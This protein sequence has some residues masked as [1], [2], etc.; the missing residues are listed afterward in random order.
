M[1]SAHAQFLSTQPVR[2]GNTQHSALGTAGSAKSSLTRATSDPLVTRVSRGEYC[3]RQKKFIKQKKQFQGSGPTGRCHGPTTATH[4]H[5][6]NRRHHRRRSTPPPPP[7]HATTATQ[8]H[9]R[10]PTPPP[11]SPPATTTCPPSEPDPEAARHHHPPARRRSPS[12][13]PSS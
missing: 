11:L 6:Q 4:H 7:Q 10:R 12:L 5:H 3:S 13:T 9:R 1:L 8:H 2:R